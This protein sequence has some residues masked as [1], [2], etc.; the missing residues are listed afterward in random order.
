MGLDRQLVQNILRREKETLGGKIVGNKLY[1]IGPLLTALLPLEP[2]ADVIRSWYVVQTIS[3]QELTAETELRAVGFDVFAPK[4]TTRQARRSMFGQS[5][6][7]LVTKPL[8]PGYLFTG[9]DV[10]R[11]SW[12]LVNDLRG[13]HRI[14]MVDLRPVPIAH[15]VIN[16]IRMREAQL[17]TTPKPLPPSNI[18][19][20]A[21]VRIIEPL[22]F[23]GLFGFVTAV[24]QPNV[25]VEIELFG[26]MV[27]LQIRPDKLVIT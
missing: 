24:G 26:R 18:K 10:A 19:V 4:V 22:A 14:L 13:I 8:M 12:Q 27:P 21:M 3:Q 23:A 9:F 20:G 16:Y 2:Q 1:P 17:R 11:E 7:V 25:R 5:K 6:H 15:A